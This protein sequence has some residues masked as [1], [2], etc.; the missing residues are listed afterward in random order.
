MYNYVRDIPEDFQ[1]VNL[2]QDVQ[3]V[4][5]SA[6]IPELTKYGSLFIKY[7]ADDIKEIYACFNE[8][9]FMSLPVYKLYPN[10]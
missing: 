6:G 9:P 3:A 4:S 8:V 2:S 5:E 1:L 10:T 7:S